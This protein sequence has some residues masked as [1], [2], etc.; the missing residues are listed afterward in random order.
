MTS[1]QTSSKLES[2]EVKDWN[3]LLTLLTVAKRVGS[4]MDH[5]RRRKQYANRQ[6]WQG[7]FYWHEVDDM[8]QKENEL[9]S[10][11]PNCL[12][13]KQKKSNQKPALAGF[14]YLIVGNN[15]WH[16]K[17]SQSIDINIK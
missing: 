4:T 9:L 15:P 11:K 6:G 2:Q 12:F 13:N 7:T 10:N 3:E 5:Q 8:K 16:S 14:V 17:D 1:I